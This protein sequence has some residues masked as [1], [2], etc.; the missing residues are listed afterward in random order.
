MLGCSKQLLMPPTM[1]KLA[2]LGADNH[3]SLR[4]WY[5]KYRSLTAFRPMQPHRGLLPWWYKY[6]LSRR[7]SDVFNWIRRDTTRKTHLHGTGS[8]ARDG[9]VVR[10]SEYG[11]AWSVSSPLACVPASTSWSPYLQPS[12]SKDASHLEMKLLTYLVEQLNQVS[13]LFL[14]SIW[15]WTVSKVVVNMTFTNFW[16]A[17]RSWYLCF[18]WF[19]TWGWENH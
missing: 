15:F 8:T 1:G 10:A 6:T 9:E 12:A 4:A 7:V 3:Q 14:H 5:L 13:L 16:W 17:M 19:S 11:L 18:A 2:Y